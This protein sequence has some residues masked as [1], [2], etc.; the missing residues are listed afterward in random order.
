MGNIS[1]FENDSLGKLNNIYGDPYNISGNIHPG[2]K[3]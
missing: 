3:R 1:D 2:V